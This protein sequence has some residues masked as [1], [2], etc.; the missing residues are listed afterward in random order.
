MHFVITKDFIFMIK[1]I[2]RLNKKLMI[3]IA[4]YYT[5]I[6]FIFPSTLINIRKGQYDSK[7]T[8]NMILDLYVD[9]CNKVDIKTLYKIYVLNQSASFKVPKGH[10]MR[11]I[12]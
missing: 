7:K 5:I 1:P 11:Y 12:K 6:S 2:M 8:T 4:T 3:L 10:F 9:L